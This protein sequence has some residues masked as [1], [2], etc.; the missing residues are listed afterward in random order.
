MNNQLLI[1]LFIIGIAF[2]VFGVLILFLPEVIE[3]KE[4]WKKEQP[5]KEK[6]KFVGLWWQHPRNVA[7][8]I[9]LGLITILSLTF[10]TGLGNN[11]SSNSTSSDST[12]S[13]S[14]SSTIASNPAS[15][16]E[17]TTSNEPSSSLQPSS[18]TIQF[19]ITFNAM[20]GT[21]VDSQIVDENGLVN[22]VT[23]EKTGYT[24]EGWFLSED[25]GVSF[26]NAWDFLTTTVTSDVTLYAKWVLNNYTIT[27]INYVGGPGIVPRTV[28]YLTIPTAPVQPTRFGYTF[29]GWYQ[30]PEF[31]NVYTFTDPMPAN[32]FTLYAKWT[33]N[34]Y[35][36]TFY[37][38]GAAAIDPITADF[39]ASITWPG[40]ITKDDSRFGGWYGNSQYLGAV[41]APQ[42]TMPGYNLNAYAKWFRLFTDIQ[43]GFNFSLGT[44]PSGRI[45]AWG[46]NNMG[47][48]GNG[49]TAIRQ[50]TPSLFTISTLNE[51][52]TITKIQLANTYGFVTTSE[53]RIFTWG[54]TPNGRLLTPT[55][56]TL[57]GLNVNET[58]TTIYTNAV[59]NQAFFLTSENR[60]FVQGGNLYGQLG[61]GNSGPSASASTPILIT[62]AGLNGGEFVNRFSIGSSFSL[63][64]TNQN[65]IFSTGENRGGQLGDGTTSGKNSFSPIS[66][67][68]LNGASIEF[69]KSGNDHTFL[70]ASDGKIYA[71]GVNAIGLGATYGDGSTTNALEPTEMVY[72]FLNAGETI[73][74]LEVGSIHN[75]AR[76][77]AGR[78]FSWGFGGESR[79]AN[80]TNNASITPIAFTTPTL[81]VGETIVNIISSPGPVSYMLTSTD[82]TLAW[83]RGMDGQIGDAD[84]NI[85]SATSVKGS[86]I[87]I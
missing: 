60:I 51:G 19:T 77:S 79:L 40:T 49:T 24:L 64:I 28:P 81:E 30:E 66:I 12:S 68:F 71:W 2:I 38:N 34:S 23:S 10:L 13:G 18:Q 45:Y 80:G 52:E 44:A 72:T 65:R 27:F 8:G 29:G 75:Y 62:I 42:T 59:A 50:N 67:E 58:I 35:T 87:F 84:P 17:A 6:K 76:T 83:G 55:L 15:S 3:G 82:R 43:V 73:V 53:G 39:G 57:S 22:A 7:L 74:E 20:D 70:I 1:F 47:Q 25:N 85:G 54:E 78:F 5:S 21:L 14:L 46:A 56:F 69:I 48:L 16:S 61:R 86:P 37:P 31:T 36:M 11:T 33:P 4:A 32:N 63:A 9:T 41:I 26:G